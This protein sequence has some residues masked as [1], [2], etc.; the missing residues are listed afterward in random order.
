LARRTKH[1]TSIVS[2]SLAKLDESDGKSGPGNLSGNTAKC[3]ELFG[4]G[5]FAFK[6]GFELNDWGDVV[7]V[8]AGLGNRM[9]L[10]QGVLF[11]DLVHG[12]RD[13]GLMAHGHV[14]RI[15]SSGRSHDD[16]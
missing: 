13:L 2:K 4:R 1:L 3:H 14:D 16:W 5:L 6:V 12:S 7:T 8:G 11:G 9:L 10:R 15:L